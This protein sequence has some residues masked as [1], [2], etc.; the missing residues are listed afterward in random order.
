MADRKEPGTLTS[1]AGELLDKARQKDAQTSFFFVT[2]F[3]RYQVQMK[4][5]ADLEKTIAEDGMTVTKEYVKG[6]RNVY[7][8]PAISE[9]NRTATAAN[10]TVVTLMKIIDQAPP[11]QDSERT[12]ADVMREL[13]ADG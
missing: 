6:R 9:Y 12:L 11:A 3:K 13:V 1:Q 7:T 10:Q 5:L 4:I 2:T 8:N